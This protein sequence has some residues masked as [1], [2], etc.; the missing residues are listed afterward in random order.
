MRLERYRCISRTGSSFPVAKTNKL[1]SSEPGP[2]LQVEKAGE[3]CS[4]ILNAENETR[5]CGRDRPGFPMTF[6]PYKVYPGRKGRDNMSS[7]GS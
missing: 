6:E 4:R 3:R 1:N 2:G 5:A 7:D